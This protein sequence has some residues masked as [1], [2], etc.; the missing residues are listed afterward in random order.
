MKKVLA[1]TIGLIAALIITACTSY[2]ITESQRGEIT[3]TVNYRE[4]ILLPD[5]AKVTVSLQDV[6]L[7]DVK[8]KVISQHSFLSRGD[9]VPL[10]FVLNFDNGAIEDNH[11]YSVSAK[12]EKEGKLLF[13]TDTH[14]GVLTDAGKTTNLDLW[15]ISVNAG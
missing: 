10:D 12:I 14:N 4:K 3:G 2:A 8:A 7:Q 13:I 9:Q 5:N 1:L 15:L 6:S 11:T